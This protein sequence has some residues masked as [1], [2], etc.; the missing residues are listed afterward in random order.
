MSLY[1]VDNCSD[2]FCN[3][4]VVYTV[5]PF[6]LT[7]LHK[8]KSRGMRSLDLETIICRR[9][10]IMSTSGNMSCNLAIFSSMGRSPSCINRK[11][12]ES[13]KYTKTIPLNQPIF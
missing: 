13:I 10:A 9:A 2:L 12:S 4:G 5:Y 8:K 11:L 7:I 3:S 6:G 1:A